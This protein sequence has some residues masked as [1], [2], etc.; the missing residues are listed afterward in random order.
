MASF[1]FK[2]ET[3]VFCWFKVSKMF[4]VLIKEQSF[5]IVYFQQQFVAQDSNQGPSSHGSWMQPLCNNIKESKIKIQTSYW[6]MSFFNNCAPLFPFCIYPFFGFE[7][8]LAL[9]APIRCYTFLG[10]C[11][12]VQGDLFSYLGMRKRP[13]I[14]AV[15]RAAD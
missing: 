10:P 4:L 3:W 1:N 14:L 13:R 12:V 15:E 8:P 6:F 11:F 7:L 9:R 2:C 5:F